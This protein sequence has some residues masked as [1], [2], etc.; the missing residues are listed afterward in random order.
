LDLHSYLVTASLDDFYKLSMYYDTC[1]AH[2]LQYRHEFTGMFH[3][4]TQVMYYH[5][6]TYVRRKQ[7]AVPSLAEELLPVV[8]QLYPDVRILYEDQPLPP[9]FHIPG[10]QDWTKETALPKN[11]DDWL[12]LVLPGRIYL[13]CSPGYAFYSESLV[14]SINLLRSCLA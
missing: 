6:P 11:A 4:V 7:A 13:L 8:Q 10:T 5:N 14:A 1:M 12:W 2:L 3:S 9:H